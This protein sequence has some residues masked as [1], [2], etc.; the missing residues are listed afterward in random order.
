MKSTTA[1]K[2][3]VCGM[4]VETATAAGSGRQ[5]S[6]FLVAPDKRDKEISCCGGVHANGPG[7]ES[8][9]PPV[10]RTGAEP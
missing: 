7:S 5:A 3:P 6:L 9:I 4:D 2:D 1:V 8:E 10:S